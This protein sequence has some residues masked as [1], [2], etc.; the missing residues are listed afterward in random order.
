[1]ER[2]IVLS[3]FLFSAIPVGA[4]NWYMLEQDSARCVPAKSPMEMAQDF[5]KKRIPYHVFHYAER[6]GKPA[7]VKVLYNDGRPHE[8]L[9]FQDR[10]FCQE[11]AYLRT[12]RP[13]FQVNLSVPH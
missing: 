4:A 10:S 13:A 11:Q 1:M 9:Y 3:V 12:G 2:F 8:L 7:I 6:N 5:D